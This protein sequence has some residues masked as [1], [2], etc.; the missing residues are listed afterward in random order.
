MKNALLTAALAFLIAL[1]TAVLVSL[2]VGQAHAGGYQGYQGYQG[3]GQTHEYQ[4]QG[5][6]YDFGNGFQQY[7]G[8]VNGRSFDGSSYDYGTG[9]QTFN[10]NF[11]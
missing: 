3:Y 2:I 5:N 11:Q 6:S 8:T 4:V 7:N 9:F 1:F 10:F